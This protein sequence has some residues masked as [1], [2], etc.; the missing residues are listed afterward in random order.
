ML[1]S[2]VLHDMIFLF[3]LPV[4]ETHQNLAS[5]YRAESGHTDPV[6][7]VLLIQPSKIYLFGL[8]NPDLRCSVLCYF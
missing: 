8:A 3:D 6:S 2:E 4:F 7:L 5:L 1:N